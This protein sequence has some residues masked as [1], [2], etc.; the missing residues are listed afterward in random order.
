MKSIRVNT[1]YNLLKTTLSLVFPLISFAYTSRILEADGLGKIQFSQSI[2]TYFTLIAMLG[3]KNYGTR[4]GAKRRE[5][6]EQ[7]SQFTC[8]IFILNM[9]STAVSYLLFFVSLLVVPKFHDY[10]SLLLIFSVMIAFTSMGMEWL[11]GALEEYRYITL[12]SLAFQLISIVLLLTLVKS[13][14]DLYIYAWILCLSSVGSNLLNLIHARKFLVIKKYKLHFKRHIK[15]ILILFA[16]ELS[17]SLYSNLDSTMLGFMTNDWEVGQ[18]SAAVKINHVLVSV[19]CSV[20]VVLLPRLSYYFEKKMMNEFNA[21]AKRAFNCL[22]LL[23][24]PSALGLIVLSA[25]TIRLFSGAGYDAAVPT[26]MIMAPVVVVIPLNTLINSQLLLPI[27]KEKWALAS[28]CTSAGV[29]LLFNSLLIPL[30]Q[31]NGAAIGTIMAETSGLVVCLLLARKKFAI[32]DFFTRCWQYIVAALPILPIGWLLQ[33]YISNGILFIIVTIAVSVA[34]YFTL[35]ML[36][37]NETCRFLWGEGMAYLR[38]FRK[39]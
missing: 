17:I 7:L 37:K 22:L 3:I 38:R 14:Q 24:V 9:L 23:A 32:R 33:Q 4:E 28:T 18:Y 8:E 35:L 5:N 12:R 6:K 21:V 10:Q 31:R 19:M 2:I 16:M 29:N 26:M 36:M 27:G 1:F 34:V 15:P 11:Y 39:K 13:K 30:L 25:P 20:G